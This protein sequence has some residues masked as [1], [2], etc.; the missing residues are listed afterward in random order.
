MLS[1]VKTAVLLAPA[2]AVMTVAGLIPLAIVAFYSVHDTFAGNAFIFVGLEWYRQL[3]ATPEFWA[4]LGRSLAFALLALAIQIPLGLAVALKMPSSGW[5]SG[6]LIVLFA[7]PLL[8]PAIVVGYLWK[9][10]S[11][12]GAGLLPFAAGLFGGRWDMNAVATSWAT[13]A[14]MDAWHWTGL[15]VLLCTAGLRAIPDDHYRAA[16]IDGASRYAVF[17]H[18]Q[19]PKLKQV[20]LIA[21]LLR[22]MD[23]F[24]VYT[25]PVVVTRGGPGVSTTFLSHELVQT[26]TIQFDLGEGGAMSVLYLLIVLAVSWAVFRVIMPRPERSDA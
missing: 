18:I 6:A 17:R 12:E 9:V 1:P 13:L 22:F 15:V 21:I 4:S 20:L 16:R 25:E 19:L 3:L 8:T 26:A 7:L 24:M 23:A 11:L 10:M 5:L 14:L 2:L